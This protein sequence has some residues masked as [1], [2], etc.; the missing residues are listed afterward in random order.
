M[1]QMLDLTYISHKMYHFLYLAYF[2]NVK[3]LRLALVYV[4]YL[5]SAISMKL[6]SQLYLWYCVGIYASDAEP[7]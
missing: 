4:L 7:Q 6:E 2:I 5:K 3:V 1:L